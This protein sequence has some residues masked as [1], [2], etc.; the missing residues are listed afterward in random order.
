MPEEKHAHGYRFIATTESP[1][2]TIKVPPIES[3]I[4]RALASGR[5]ACPVGVCEDLIGPQM[6]PELPLGSS[7]NIH[8]GTVEL[9]FLGADVAKQLA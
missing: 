9:R 8:D 4:H 1:K 3:L 7:E 5:K 6:K 2:V